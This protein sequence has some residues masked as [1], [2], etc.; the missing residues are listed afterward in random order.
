MNA[1]VSYQNI[2]KHFGEVEVLA[3]VD[4]QC[5]AGAIT[6]IVGASG[7]GKTTLLRLAN[8][9]IQADAGEVR[10]FGDPV[11]STHAAKG[12]GEQF[13]RQIGYAVQGAGLFP[14]LS[15]KQNVTLVAKLEGWQS[16]EIDER[17]VQLLAAM[18]LPEDVAQRLP[19]ELSGGQQQ[20]LGICRAL[21]LRPRLLLLDE[22][23][24]AVDPITRIEL[25]E[26]FERVKRKENVSGLLVTHDLREARRLAEHL[27]ILHQGKV[28]QSGPTVE[29]LKAPATE[30][31][32]LLVDS[33]LE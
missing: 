13:R 23:F 10:V 14:H 5:P 28:H 11:P 9:V 16:S 22:P 17:F 25:Y 12:V 30:F 21:M 31:V 19:R 33:Q 29:V 20:R 32:Q 1:C 15:A 7:S 26:H 24:S 8:G 4:V 2:R 6:A 18:E 27:V 3:N